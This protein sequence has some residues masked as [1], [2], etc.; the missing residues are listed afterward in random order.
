MCY[1]I[2]FSNPDFTSYWLISSLICF[3]WPLKYIIS[4]SNKTPFTMAIVH[5]NDP[6]L[7][8]LGFSV[9]RCSFLAFF[10]WIF[11]N[12]SVNHVNWLE[13]T[14]RHGRP[15]RETSRAQCL[16]HITTM[17][18]RRGCRPGMG[19]QYIYTRDKNIFMYIPKC[20]P[21]QLL[22]FVFFNNLSIIQNEML[23]T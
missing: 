22:I 9:C 15:G 4:I 17:F 14:S 8:L 16:C 7:W 2:N 1:S 13:N 11:K 12:N 5:R 6:F 3:H 19:N 21:C 18:I 23:I 10:S 20:I